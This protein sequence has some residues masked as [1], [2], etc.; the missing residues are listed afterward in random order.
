MSAL[1]SLS[2]PP[3]EPSSPPS[4]FSLHACSTLQAA[5]LLPPAAFQ[6]PSLDALPPAP[7]PAS[8]QLYSFER[9][10]VSCN[11]FFF[12]FCRLG[13]G[14]PFAAAARRNLLALSLFQIQIQL[15]PK[16]FFT[17]CDPLSVKSGLALLRQ[18]VGSDHMPPP[19]SSAPPSSSPSSSPGHAS[20][21]LSS[22]DAVIVS[23]AC[24][25]GLQVYLSRSARAQMRVRSTNNVTARR[26]GVCSRPTMYVSKFSIPASFCFVIFLQSYFLFAILGSISPTFLMTYFL[27]RHLAATRTRSRVK[28]PRRCRRSLDLLR[29]VSCST[30]RTRCNAS[31]VCM[32]IRGLIMPSVW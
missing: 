3:S 1:L 2:A 8:G 17:A 4:S 5:E 21:E 22:E 31:F 6:P 12:I 23:R 28:W 20:V 25:R 10:F 19:P 15:R 9:R 7:A 26:L 16:Q 32:L 29:C 18:L 11:A 27:F 30:Q 24:I 13:Q 14:S